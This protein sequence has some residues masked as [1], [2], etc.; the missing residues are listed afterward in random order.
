MFKSKE[1]LIA[2]LGF[3]ILNIVLYLFI[4]SFNR[5]IPFNQTNY[6]DNFHHFFEDPRIK[7]E[8]FDLLNA[9]G[10]SDAQWYLK[11]ALDGYPTEIL[12]APEGYK[13]AWE[14]L[15][16]A[17]FPIYPLVLFLFNL[18]FKDI[19]F[20]AFLVTN[21]I[22]LTNFFSLY[23][24]IT[25]LFNKN[26]AIKTIFLIFLFP[27]SIFFRSYFTE[28][29]YLLLLIWFSYFLIKKEFLLSASV[30]G[31]MNITRGSG[32]FLNILILI[33]LLKEVIGKRFPLRYLPISIYLLVIPLGVW[34]LYNYLQTGDYLY[35]YSTQTNWFESGN[36]LT[37]LIHNLNQVFSYN[38]LA[39]HLFHSSKIDVISLIT[40]LI[41]LI[42][43]RRRLPI[44][45]WW[46]SLSLW[47]LPILVKD[48]I[49][50][51]RFQVVNFPLFIFL[52]LALNQKA[53]Y[54]LAALFGA[55]LFLVSL[56]FVNW[57]WIG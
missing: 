29:L 12:S 49:S 48:L 21:L 14:I 34:M 31:V 27:F 20:T 39:L 28:G 15:I 56:F 11:I 22:M 47:V 23:F 17:F 45:L 4:I 57:Y 54:I 26:V 2:L 16:Y 1:F 36:M 3:T 51:S 9:L 18:V 30:L 6:I 52:A 7:N 44:R 32:V 42:V 55:L 53:Y 19:E 43:S 50:F 5:L 38:S 40:S 8:Q 33:Y 37:P 46:I 25:K 24:V 10:Q 41:L 35:F 13:N